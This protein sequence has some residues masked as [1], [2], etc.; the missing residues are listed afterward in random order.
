MLRAVYSRWV[1]II[2]NYEN[3]F[4][5]NRWDKFCLKIEQFIFVFRCCS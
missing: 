3:L 5:I 2:F 1:Q 4:I